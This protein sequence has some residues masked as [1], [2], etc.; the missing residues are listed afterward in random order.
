MEMIPQ[1]RPPEWSLSNLTQVE[2]NQQLVMV[3]G[4]LFYDN[5]HRVNGDPNDPQRGQPHRYSLWEVHPITQF[6]VCTKA[7][8]SCDPARPG[9]WAP[10]GQ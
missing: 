6:V 7:D 8:N 4:G 1:N 3:T 5:I 2:S 9:D 10:L